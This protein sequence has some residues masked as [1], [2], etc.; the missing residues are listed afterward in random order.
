MRAIVG[1][2]KLD[3]EWYSDSITYTVRATRSEFANR[4]L[5]RDAQS[6]PCVRRVTASLTKA[7]NRPS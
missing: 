2:K 7:T 3:G 1:E 6:F 5:L 4:N